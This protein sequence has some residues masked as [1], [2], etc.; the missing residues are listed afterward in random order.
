MPGEP[1]TGPGHIQ[2]PDWEYGLFVRPLPCIEYG[3]VTSVP[4]IGGYSGSSGSALG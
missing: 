1:I 3:S 4:D 2:V